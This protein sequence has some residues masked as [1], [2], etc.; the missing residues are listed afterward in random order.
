MS[1]CDGHSTIY[2]LKNWT[3]SIHCLAEDDQIS[4]KY[5]KYADLHQHVYSEV[6]SKKPRRANVSK[7]TISYQNT[8]FEK[9]NVYDI[10]LSDSF[11]ETKLPDT[12][13]LVDIFANIILEKNNRFENKS[14]FCSEKSCKHGRVAARIVIYSNEP[15]ST[16]DYCPM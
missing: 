1:S 7:Y 14:L 9:S 12:S 15:S 8:D 3:Q 5:A 11:T 13:A 2:Y 16:L 4:L 6:E 10:I